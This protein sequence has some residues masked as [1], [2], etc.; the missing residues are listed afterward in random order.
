M[1]LNQIL[2]SGVPGQ[3]IFWSL[4]VGNKSFGRID[5]H[6]CRV[7]KRTLLIPPDEEK[8]QN[9][10]YFFFAGL[11]TAGSAKRP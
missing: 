8:S 4:E 10:C 6:F 11:T 9:R 1:F 7:V 3:E 5:N 2:A